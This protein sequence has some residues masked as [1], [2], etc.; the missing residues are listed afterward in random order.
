MT[1][2]A[3]NPAPIQG[4]P[5]WL[6]WR[7]G[8]YGA[9]EAPILVAGD[10]DDWWRL[11]ARKLRLIDPEDLDQQTES[12]RWGLLLEDPIADAYAERVG[13]KVVRV[14]RPLAHPERSHVR[15]S[16]DRRRKRGR[17]VVELKKW[18]FPTDDF[19]PGCAACRTG[20]GAHED[21]G[22]G[23]VPERWIDQIQQQLYV[24]DYAQADIA[25]LFA[26]G[27]AQ[28]PFRVYH[29]GRDQSRIDAILALEDAAWAY[30]ARGEMPPWPGPAPTRLRIRDGEL[31]ADAV[32]AELLERGH[33]ARVNKQQAE[34]ADKEL[35]AEILAAIGDW[36]VVRGGSV[37]V[38]AR[39]NRDGQKV[40]WEL[41]AKAHRKRLEG[42]IAEHADDATWQ[43]IT[44]DLDTIESMF[45]T[46]TPGA[47]P[48]RYVP[49]KEASD[50]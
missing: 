22:E 6:A 19:G 26:G 11:H 32:L 2:L 27:S 39:P 31:E 21:A 44:E 38:T 1:A 41:I 34:K 20:F 29:V 16:L 7:L 17:V 45:T 14:N 25:V 50:E 13:E 5:A 9:S 49:H 15:A 3:T 12:M 33:R 48:L 23:D 28:D 24:T 35:T 30:V 4:T 43:S 47:R 18:G 46:T 37:D 40:A 8:G 42:L 10:Q 36:P